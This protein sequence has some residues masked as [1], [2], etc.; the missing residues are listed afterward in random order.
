M[1]TPRRK[2]TIEWVGDN[3]V[4]LSGATALVRESIK[5]GAKAHGVKA[6]WNEEGG[7]WRVTGDKNALNEFLNDLQ[8]KARDRIEFITSTKRGERA[9]E[10]PQPQVQVQVQP[11]QE[12][13]SLIDIVRK[14]GFSRKS[15]TLLFAFAGVGKTTFSAWL[16]HELLEAGLVKNAV[17]ILT[18]PNVL[19]GEEPQIEGIKKLVPNVEYTGPYVSKVIKTA[20]KVLSENTDTFVVIDSIGAVSLKMSTDIMLSTMRREGDV[21]EVL[22][23]VPRVSPVISGLA[24]EIALYVT[25]N[26]NTVLITSHEQQ[27]IN[28]T[29]NKESAKPSFTARATHSVYAVWRLILDDATDTRYLK[30]VVHRKREYVGRV[31]Q[32]PIL[33]L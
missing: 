4:R 21:G 29:W 15:I 19:E 31:L 6:E 23:A 8:S 17:M 14:A 16:A 2:I 1:S 26:N 28:K 33:T 9:E 20:I 3:E 7:F 12:G 25:Q 10:Q 11:Q 30:V 27:M 24:Q 18:E 5:D 32:L 22:V 13:G